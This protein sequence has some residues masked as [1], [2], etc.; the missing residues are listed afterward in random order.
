MVEQE[1]AQGYSA[2]KG[3]VKDPS[4]FAADLTVLDVVC[5][6]SPGESPEAALKS[7][8][9]KEKPKRM[10]ERACLS[11]LNFHENSQAEF[12]PTL[13]IVTAASST[14]TSVT[15][16]R[17]GCPISWAFT[18]GLLSPVCTPQCILPYTF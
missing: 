17:C 12:L 16:Q 14:N 11:S 18:G 15:Q 13:N 10:P 3:Q 9:R 8:L 7:D 1:L 4:P 2:G 6:A 5:A